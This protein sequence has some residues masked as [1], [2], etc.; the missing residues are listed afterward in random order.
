MEMWY[1]V[2]IK[3]RNRGENMS[4]ATH[5]DTRILGCKTKAPLSFSVCGQLISPSGFV[6][7]RRCFGEN[8]LIMITEGTLYITANN[9]EH[10]LTAG[11]YILL[12]AWEEHFGHRSSEGKL[13]YLWAHF[14]SDTG[15]DTVTREDGEYTYLLPEASVL[16]H[17][18]RTAQLFHQLMDMSLEEKLYTQNMSD[19]AMSLLLMEIS[20]EYF[21]FGD[22]SDKLPLA[23]ISAREW[24]K[25]HYYLPFDVTELADAVGYSADYLSSLFKRSIGI[26]IVRYTNQLRIKTAKTL[27]SNY[28]ITIKE[29]AFSCG[30]SD[31]KYF[32][33][34]F[35]QLEGITPSEYKNSFGRKNIN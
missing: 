31:E 20:R 26:S 34:V 2:F 4:S 24:I 15:F 13:S 22:N 11:H 18:G 17:S 16:S 33:K 19:Y 5:P 10:T 25:N 1:N 14:R 35:K 29:A 6:H 12:K 9:V 8:V 7:H 28:D 3:T 30:F 32:M 23:V 21:R 27:L